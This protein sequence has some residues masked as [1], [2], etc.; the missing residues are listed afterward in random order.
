MINHIFKVFIYLL[1][2][3]II[4]GLFTI[5]YYLFFRKLSFYKVNRAMIFIAVLSA[6]IIPALDITLS[7]DYSISEIVPNYQLDYERVL[8]LNVVGLGEG[9]PPTNPNILEN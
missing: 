6:L 1:E 3:S 5:L 8:K 4:M 7:E 2:A 9:L